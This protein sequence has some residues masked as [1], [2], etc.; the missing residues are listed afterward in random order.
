MP[1]PNNG[2][3]SPKIAR[4]RAKKL[5]NSQ[6]DLF[7]ALPRDLPARDQQDLMERPFFSLS[8]NKRTTPIEY[9]VGDNY[10]HVSANE[11]YGL[12]TIWDA[13]ILIWAASQLTEARE[14]GLKTSRFFR[15]SAYDLL[16]FI[17][18][19]TSGRDYQEL[20]AALNRLRATTV[21]TSIRQGKRKEHHVFGWLNEWKEIIDE[22]GHSLGLE[23]IIPDWLYDG[24]LN[25]RLILTIDPAYFDLTSGIERWLYRVVRKHGG[26]QK[27]GWSFTF[28]QL[29]EKSGSLDRFANF[30]MHIRGIVERQSIPEYWLSIHRNEYDEELLHFIRRNCLPPGHEGATGIQLR[31]RRTKPK[32]LMK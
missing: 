29:Y 20:K 23:F 24:I 17:H 25:Q 7:I 6:L 30:A 28:R 19:G 13:D 9:R 22:H 1:A 12:A 8:K 18:R 21:V 16:K 32:L 14:R 11:K 4:S 3:A 31:K 26:K 2:M 27:T 5:D 15:L 10:I